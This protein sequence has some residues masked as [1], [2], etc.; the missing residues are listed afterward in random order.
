MLKPNVAKCLNSSCQAE[1][2][3][4]GDGKLFVEPVRNAQRDHARRVVWL[5]SRCSRDHLL[6]YD[7]GGQQF[8]LTP[9]PTHGKRIA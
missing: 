2:K 5:C 7:D 4:M 3:R 6:H 1:F 8:V 9:R